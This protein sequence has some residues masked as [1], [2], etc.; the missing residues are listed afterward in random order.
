MF[1]QENNGLYLYSNCSFKFINCKINIAN[2]FYLK[3]YIMIYF[4]GFPVN[5]RT[6]NPINPE[7]N[8]PHNIPIFASST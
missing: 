8:E 2:V 5:L 7:I 1:N 4:D 6:L 3:F